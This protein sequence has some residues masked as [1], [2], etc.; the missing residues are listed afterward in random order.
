MFCLG[1][2]ARPGVKKGVRVV[3]GLCYR[4]CEWGGL[5]CFFCCFHCGYRGG[6]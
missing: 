6:A 2:D 3:D 1:E 5:A 4:L